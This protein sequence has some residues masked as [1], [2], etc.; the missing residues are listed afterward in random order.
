EATLATLVRQLARQALY[1]WPFM[2]KKAEELWQS[3]G[4]PGKPV[5]LGFGGIRK[6]DPTGWRVTKGA[7]LFPKKES[8]TA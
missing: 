5:G 8:A 3:L 6:V 2:P 1:L 7:S 4:A